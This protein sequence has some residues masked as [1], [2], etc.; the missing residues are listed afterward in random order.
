[1]T[2]LKSK[3]LPLFNNSV[4]N[5]GILSLQYKSIACYAELFLA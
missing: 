5:I 3:I 1:M 4:V 2:E